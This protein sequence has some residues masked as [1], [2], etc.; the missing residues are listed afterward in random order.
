[1]SRTDA[2]PSHT[3]RCFG[4]GDDNPCGLGL[5]AWRD[6]EDA[7]RGEVT[8]SDHHSSGLLFAHGGAVAT[9]LDDCL[10]FLLYVFQEP[11]VTAKL[12]VNYRKP[13]L[14]NHRYDMRARVTG[15][16]GRKVHSA[17]E[18]LDGDGEVAADGAALFVTVTYDHFV[19]DLTEEDRERAR[20]MGLDLPW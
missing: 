16:D 4:C 1:M 13:V 8:F 17:I 2:L 5:R 11:A 18:M 3:P 10:G 7:V 19:K 9:A 15:R 12:E 14:V 20:G 6:G